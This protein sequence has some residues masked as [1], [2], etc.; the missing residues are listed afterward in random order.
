MAIARCLLRLGAGLALGVPVRL[1]RRGLR[2][3]G[4]LAGGGT[5]GSARF[6]GGEDVLKKREMLPDTG[7]HF[8]IG[9]APEGIQ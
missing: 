3:L 7:E 6:A 4:G 8:V 9:D 2:R 1:V 5:F